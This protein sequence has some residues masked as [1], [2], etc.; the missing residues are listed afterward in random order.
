MLGKVFQK[1]YLPS[2]FGEIVAGLLLG[3]S[4]FGHYFSKNYEWV[5]IDFDPEGKLLSLFYY[6]GLIFLM[7]TA[8]FS[9]PQIRSFTMVRNSIGLILGALP[10]PFFIAFI[11]ADSIPNDL[12]PNAT[13]FKIVVACAAS[14]TSIPVLSRIFIEL[15]LISRDFA[16]NVL[17]A[18]AFQDLILWTVLSWAIS[19]QSSQLSNAPINQY[20]STI[21]MTSL[22][23]LISVVLLPRI[24]KH[25]NG[26]QRVNFSDSNLVGY[27]MLITLS[28]IV[29]ANL[30]DVSVVL[31]ALVAGITLIRSGG[32]RVDFVKDSVVRFSHSFLIPIYFALV[33][34]R[35][36]LS[37]LI[38][39]LLVIEVLFLTSIIKIGSVA[40][41]ARFTFTNWKVALDYGISMNA[42]GGPG[43]VLASLAFDA[44]IIDSALFT[45]FV[46]ISLVT[47]AIAGLWLR[48]RKDAI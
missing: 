4:I 22:F 38:S 3:P 12:T 41:L 20:L 15:G 27:S 44:K 45:T 48:L 21:A 2:V 31:G 46:L 33:G 47:S 6:L 7:L 28:I 19:L 26:I 29:L 16:T 11:T 39:P 13:A 18:A 8:G 42:R 23:L 36:D 5:F 37:N 32:K 14:V 43:I 10:I 17:T 35:I 40:L 9:I 34:L 30:L 24:F 25:L 1:L